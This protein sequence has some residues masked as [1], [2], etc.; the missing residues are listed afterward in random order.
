MREQQIWGTKCNCCP[1]QD[2]KKS[3]HFLIS[4]KQSTG[5]TVSCT[6]LAALGL[7]TG[8]NLS[9]V[10]FLPRPKHFWRSGCR[11]GVKKQKKKLLNIGKWSQQIHNVLPA[12]F[13][14]MVGHVAG[15]TIATRSLS[16]GAFVEVMHYL[17]ALATG[18]KLHWHYKCCVKLSSNRE[19]MLFISYYWMHVFCQKLEPSSMLHQHNT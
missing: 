4:W 7:M 3:F 11:A 5:T 17:L 18:R 13:F 10:N 16:H 8:E 6:A 2:Y 12:P 9:R 14:G 15:F 1:N 19:Y